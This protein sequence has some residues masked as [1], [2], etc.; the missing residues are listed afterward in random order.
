MHER[1]FFW[2]RPGRLL[3]Y[4]FPEAGADFPAENLWRITGGE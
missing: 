1:F 3:R 4:S 2:L